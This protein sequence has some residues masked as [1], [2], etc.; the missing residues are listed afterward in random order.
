MNAL[1]I[2]KADKTL[3]SILYT[4]DRNPHMWWRELERILNEA[5]TIYNRSEIRVYT[6]KP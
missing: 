6:P 4:E 3:D 2:V 5:F 1:D